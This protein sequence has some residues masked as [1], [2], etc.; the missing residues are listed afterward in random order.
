M[1]A[2]AKGQKRQGK[3]QS[4]GTTGRKRRGNESHQAGLAM[5][6]KAALPAAAPLAVYPPL[7]LVAISS[8]ATTTVRPLLLYFTSSGIKTQKKKK[9]E[10]KY[11]EVGKP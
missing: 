10:K 7:S 4:I 9:K 3:R 6:G 11:E 8:N 2:T 1:L 5:L